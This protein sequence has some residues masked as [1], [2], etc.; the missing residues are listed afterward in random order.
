LAPALLRSFAATAS[1]TGQLGF[2]GRTL[3]S[4]K[5]A[6]HLQPHGSDEALPLGGDVDA[7]VNLRRGSVQL[8]K[9][10]LRSGSSQLQASGALAGGR[11]QLQLHFVSSDINRL[12][13]AVAAAY[14]RLEPGRVLPVFGGAMQVQA[15]LAGSLSAPVVSGS[16]TATAARWGNWRADT[17]RAQG[18]VGPEALILEHLLYRRGGQSVALSGT[19]DLN[20]YRLEAASTLALHGSVRGLDVAQ[21]MALSQL[22]HLPHITGVLNATAALSGT[23]GQPVL[24]GE[25]RLETAEW[26]EQKIR[27]ATAQFRLQGGQFTC[28]QFALTLAHTHISGGFRLGLRDRTYEVH[29]ASAGV[30]LADVALLQSPRLSIRGR[31]RF[32][33]AGSGNLAQPQGTL[34]LA[35]NGLRGGGESLG[36]VGAKLEIEGHRVRFQAAD[37]LTNGSFNLTG[38]IG[39]GAPYPVEA[40]LRLR[41]YDFDAWLRRFTPADITGHSRVSGTAQI[42]GPLGVPDQLHA[43][44][45][46]DTVSVALNGLVIHNQGAIE[47]SAGAQRLTLA[48]A[49][50]VAPD[51]SFTASGSVALGPS[52][53]A[54]LNFTTSL[55]G[56]L[57]GRINLALLHLLHP[58]TRATGAITVDARVGGTAGQPHLSGQVLVENGSL[59]EAGLPVAFEHIQGN[60][61]LNGSRMEIRSLT[62][63]TGSGTLAISGYASKTAPGVSCN[64]A[65]QGQNLRLRY[66]GISSS[67]NLQLRLTSSGRNTLLAG[68]VQ[69]T[70]VAL[71]PRFDL[72]LFIAGLQQNPP[73]PNPDSVLSRIRM[74][75]HVTTGAQVLVA[76]NMARL[77][78]QVDLNLRGTL[79]DPSVTG[80]A[81][82]SSGELLF[83]G[84]QFRITKAQVVFANPFRIEPVLDVGLTTRV[85][86]Y[87]I[88]I[89]L[90]GPADK[91]ALSYR[92]D[93][94]LSSSDVMALLAT[95]EPTQA[96]ASLT[97]AGNFAPSEQLL[98]QALNNLVASR[99]HRLFGITQLQI[100][101]DVGPL[102]P[103]GNGGSITVEQQVSRNVKLTYMQNL[104]SS[105]QDIVQVDWTISR[106]L[107]ITLSRD[108][109][110][111]Y[112]LKFTFRHRAH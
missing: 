22:P 67:G 84:N 46:L 94:P 45:S 85:Q 34:T 39:T 24:A 112:G 8:E 36:D 63:D 89:D 81:G 77:Q 98:G 61:L 76:S 12:R 5:L 49:H 27:A 4:I 104:A 80:R 88:T 44:I 99:L 92:S 78:L 54:P 20:Q 13:P 55:A 90:S 108:Q 56:R 42:A 66:R 70:R 38:T 6:V 109:F 58:A 28:P 100:N 51:T 83:A 65:I 40:K 86:A 111:L 48:P 110:G 95:G 103:T 32:Q 9:V 79:A 26:R 7:R 82:A 62:A 43:G 33:F 107:G 101:P 64:L 47:L 97:A 72:A 17:L 73:L 105:S 23:W 57:T 75:I 21:A 3:A 25:A 41:D 16:L 69:L 10:Q 74:N 14:A 106:F 29:A 37:I 59:A 52:L 68:D 11:G 35:T 15:S 2:Q 71:D 91:M 18:S 93:P 53:R 87:D 60:L 30:D 19:V 96:N 50:I 102:G 1:G 31:L